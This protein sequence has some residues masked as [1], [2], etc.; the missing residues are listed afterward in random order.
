MCC[1]LSGGVSVFVIAIVA[2]IVIVIVIVFVIVGFTVHAARMT[3]PALSWY[4]A[5]SNPYAFNIKLLSLF[6]LQTYRFIRPCI[7]LF[8]V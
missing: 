8:S 7:Y 3:T 2:V 1:F 6:F 4:I 5:L